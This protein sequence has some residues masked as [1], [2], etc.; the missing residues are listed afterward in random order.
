[1]MFKEGKDLDTRYADDAFLKPQEMIAEADEAK[2]LEY[3]QKVGN[4]QLWIYTESARIENACKMAAEVIM[5]KNRELAL[6]KKRQASDQMSDPKKQTSKPRKRAKKKEINPT[7]E[8]KEAE[9]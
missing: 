8:N 2:L 3:L 7:Q 5:E 9:A 4:R 1:M 6:Y